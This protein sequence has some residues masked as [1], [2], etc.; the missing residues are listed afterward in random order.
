MN[1]R[2]S[3]LLRTSDGFRTACSEVIR[4]T[5]NSR[6]LSVA[7]LYAIWRFHIFI[8]ISINEKV[9]EQSFNIS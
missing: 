6:H 2:S 8:C 5:D 9:E 3:I 1:S 7:K 4:K